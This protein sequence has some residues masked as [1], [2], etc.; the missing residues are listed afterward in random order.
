MQ[1]IGQDHYLN[2]QISFR[3]ANLYLLTKSD[4]AIVEASGPYITYDEFRNI[5]S[6]ITQMIIEYGITKLI[7]DQRK[8]MVCNQAS[9]EWLV[10]EWKDK[11]IRHGLTR[12]RK[13]LLSDPTFCQKIDDILL[14]VSTNFS[15]TQ[16][17]QLDI[18][19]CE[20]LN[21]AIEN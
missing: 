2:L 6:Y 20:S 15:Q 18:Q 4:I 16:S 12:Y 19:C 9:V 7:F 14:K 13:I 5:F 11:I 3:N 17:K 8:L 10:T 1:M 21:E